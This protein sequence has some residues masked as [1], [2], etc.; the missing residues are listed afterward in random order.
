MKKR[1][2]LN[3]ILVT[4][5]LIMIVF[6]SLYIFPIKSIFLNSLLEKRLSA[7][8]GKEV[9][10]GSSK[11]YLFN[12]I[13]IKD[14]KIDM[15]NASSF[16]IKEAIVRY[17]FFPLLRKNL[18]AK[19]E[20]KSVAASQPF[21]DYKI[22]DIML[23]AHALNSIQ[24]DTVSAN[25]N[26]KGDSAIIDDMEVMGQKVKVTGDIKLEGGDVSKYNIKVFIF[27]DLVQD[28]PDNFKNIL[29]QK[30]KDEWYTIELNK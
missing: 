9:S 5:T 2:V 1:L 8:V 30:E 26:V 21:N 27:K 25:L 6:L 20:L 29:F 22:V 18:I 4:F 14:L 17:K 11:L 23:K 7:E 15:N 16:L 24:F 12:R 19:C 13:E 10:I 3:L 28:V